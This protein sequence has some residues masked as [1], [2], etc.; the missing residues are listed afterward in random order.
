MFAQRWIGAGGKSGWSPVV[1]GGWKNAKSPSRRYVPLS[2][3]VIE[4]HLRREIAVG[5]YPL[6][7][8]DV[9]RFLVC[10]FDGAGCQLDTLAYLE[11]AHELDVPAVLERSRSGNGGQAWIFFPDDVDRS[12]T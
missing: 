3:E 5:V 4:A 10:D 2:D 1:K 11:V 7:S 8:G 12:G 6:M 9:C